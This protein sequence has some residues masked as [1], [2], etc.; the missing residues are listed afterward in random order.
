M[1]Y[2]HVPNSCFLAKDCRCVSAQQSTETWPSSTTILR[3][4]K[5]DL[6]GTCAFFIASANFAVPERAI[7]PRDERRSS[8]VMPMPV[9]SMVI[10]LFSLFACMHAATLLKLYGRNAF[11]TQTFTGSCP[12]I[13]FSFLEVLLLAFKVSGVTNQ[14]LIAEP[15]AKKAFEHVLHAFSC[16]QHATQFRTCCGA[17]PTHFLEARSTVTVRCACYTLMPCKLCLCILQNL[18]VCAYCRIICTCRS[19]WL[20][21]SGG[22]P[23]SRCC[24]MLTQCN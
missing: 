23:S 13:R 6:Q 1:H 24:H 3:L 7:V 5:W 10:V 17:H 19:M 11:G 8:L 21:T 20:Q 14:A 22:N 15:F 2:M 16:T 18:Y 4:R 9:S 12:W